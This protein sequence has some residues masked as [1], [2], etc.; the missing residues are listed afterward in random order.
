VKE[1]EENVMTTQTISPNA[2]ALSAEEG[3]TEQ[4]LNILFGI[5]MLAKVTNDD[6]DG[7]VAILY[8]NVPP[9]AGPPLH[10]HSREDEW[11]YVLEGQVT[12]EVDGQQTILDAGGSAFAPRGTAH[13]YQNFGPT[14]ARILVLFMPGDFQRFFEDLALLMRGL[15][16]P[17]LVRVEQLMNGYGVEVMGPPLPWI[18]IDSL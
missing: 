17:D 3:R 15:S 18:A 5:E 8:E 16:A 13:T 7:R 2:F 10:R 11:F 1:Q 9:M 4:P 6:T 14:A 12:I